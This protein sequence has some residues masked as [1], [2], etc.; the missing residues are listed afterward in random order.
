MY[1]VTYSYFHD[2]DGLRPR[3]TSYMLFPFPNR[4]NYVLGKFTGCSGQ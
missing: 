2:P 4:D 3:K 1:A